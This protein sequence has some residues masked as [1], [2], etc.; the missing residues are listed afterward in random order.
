MNK[1]NKRKNPPKE[2]VVGSERIKKTLN[3]KVKR[4]LERLT[5][6]ESEILR[7]TLAKEQKYV[8]A[9]CERSLIDEKLS[10]EDNKI[11]LRKGNTKGTII[12]HFKP[13]G[14]YA[15]RDNTTTESTKLC[16]NDIKYRPDLRLEYDNLILCC[17]GNINYESENRKTK[18]NT[19][20]VKSTDE[21]FHH[22]D[23]LKG[24]KELCHIKNPATWNKTD[25]SKIKFSSNFNIMSSDEELKEELKNKLNLN[26]SILKR[27]RESAWNKIATRIANET[28]IPNWERGGENV[29]LT[30][31]NIIQEYKHGKKLYNEFVYHDFRSCII[32]LLERKLQMLK[33]KQ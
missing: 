26:E 2:F 3:A 21:I 15:G 25:I 20:E 4:P 16:D 7:L 31:S 28:K 33:R 14:I 5:S 6:E 1:I 24:E 29:I 32:Y 27:H 9:Y 22:C 11:K 30:I 12:E 18:N 13:N 17:S 19:K 10:E 8:C 23:R